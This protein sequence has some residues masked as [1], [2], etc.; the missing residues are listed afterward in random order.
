[1]VILGQMAIR[2]DLEVI[3]NK[4][5]G[6]KRETPWARLQRILVQEQVKLED[7]IT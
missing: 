4:Y 1:M 3:Q 5:I 6:S 7:G 2:V